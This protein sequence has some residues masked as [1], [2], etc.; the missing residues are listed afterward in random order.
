M[1]GLLNWNE[2]DEEQFIN[3][4][5][6]PTNLERKKFHLQSEN[7]EAYK[8]PENSLPNLQRSPSGKRNDSM[9]ELLKWQQEEDIRGQP[10]RQP[11]IEPEQIDLLYRE[12][13]SISGERK[14]KEGK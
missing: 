1:A 3:R 7:T 8:M 12:N 10:R 9:N 6:M 5:S 14:K 4:H 11:N 13:R 2:R